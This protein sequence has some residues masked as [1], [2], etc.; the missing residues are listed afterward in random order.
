MTVYFTKLKA[1]RKE[2]NNSK[3]QCTCKGLKE[4]QNYF[5]MEYVMSF[6]MG[7]NESTAQVRR[8]LLLMEPIPPINK[9]FSLVS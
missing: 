1:L 9:V 6:L 4:L 3:P 2:L 8:Q 5:H 7:L